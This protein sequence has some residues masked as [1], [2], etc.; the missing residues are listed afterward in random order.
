M[1][2]LLVI[3]VISTPAIAHEW[4]PAECCQSMDC[5]PISASEVESLPNGDW[6]VK[7]T[8]ETFSA[9]HSNSPL[10]HI[11]YSPDGGFHRCSFNADRKSS[12]ICLFVPM[13]DGS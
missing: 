7:E 2:I 13:P 5:Y 4:Y 3:S 12:S 11:R 9:P 10:K 6:R 8:G 1:K